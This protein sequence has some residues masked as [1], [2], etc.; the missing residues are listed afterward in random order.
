MGVATDADKKGDD[1]MSAALGTTPPP[2]LAE[3]EQ[4]L[5]GR[6]TRLA[7]SLRR[8]RADLLQRISS[9]LLDLRPPHDLSDL[10]TFEYGVLAMLTEV[11]QELEEAREIERS[12][13]RSVAQATQE[14]ERAKT[15]YERCD[16]LT[17]A[18]PKAKAIERHHLARIE[19]EAYQEALD[20]IRTGLVEMERGL[21][22][23]LQALQPEFDSYA[24]AK[25][26]AMVKEAERAI[27][28]AE[29]KLRHA[30]E[31]KRRAEIFPQEFNARFGLEGHNGDTA[32]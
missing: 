14:A 21:S 1:T 24:T 26:T 31:L 6:K 22:S 2:S 17:D 10:R 30:A 12:Y 23:R 4:V 19:S 9:R 3:L 7:E 25:V 29:G 32:N 27:E 11:R 5:E 20:A 28:E 15:E 13:G 16:A 8:P 18:L